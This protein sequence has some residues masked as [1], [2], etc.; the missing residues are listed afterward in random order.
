[1]SRPHRRAC[2]CGFR[3]ANQ[4]DWRGLGDGDVGAEVDVLDGGEELDAFGHG[5]L[6]GFA[7]G[8]EA[9]AAGTLVDDSSGYGVF[10]VVGTGSAAA[11]DQ[12]RAAHE[13][14]GDLIA[15]EVD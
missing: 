12:A 7:A 11:I 4:H 2:G 14:V 5:A 6:E 13:A 8:D 1:M 3:R 10:E 15:A 9:C